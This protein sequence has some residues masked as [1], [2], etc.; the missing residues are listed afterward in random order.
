MS[1]AFEQA[2]GGTRGGNDFGIDR[3]AGVSISAMR[4]RP[5]SCV[6]ADKKLPTGAG[7]A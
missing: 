3:A 4:N 7:A 1:K 5:G 2:G 6:T